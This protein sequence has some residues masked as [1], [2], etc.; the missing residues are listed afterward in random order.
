MLYLPVY[1]P[2]R[3]RVRGWASWL[4]DQGSECYP[5]GIEARYPWAWNEQ[6]QQQQEYYSS[7]PETWSSF[8]KEASY[9]ASTTQGG[10]EFHLD[11]TLWAKK[12]RR[13]DVRG[14]TVDFSLK[15][16]PRVPSKPRSKSSFRFPAILL[17]TIWYTRIRSAHRRRVSKVWSWRFS[18][19][20]VYGRWRMLGRSLVA[21]FLTA[22]ISFQSFLKCGF[23]TWVAYSRWGRINLLCRTRNY[24]RLQ[25]L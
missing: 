17:W 10:R 14:E 11:T 1:L 20:W 15:R 23:H 3:P 9:S 22:S 18:S 25:D 19:R 8:L 5:W 21:R 7:A 2:V 13:W 4:S 16:C 12:W 6:D 24:D